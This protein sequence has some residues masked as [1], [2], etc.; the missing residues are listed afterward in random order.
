MVTLGGGYAN[1][2]YRIKGS[3]ADA[4]LRIFARDGTRRDM[5][6]ALLAQVTPVV[7]VPEVLWS[8]EVGGQS[9]LLLSH[10]DGVLLDVVL[11]A[12]SAE[13][14]AACGQVVGQALAPIHDM[15]FDGTGFLDARLRPV[16]DARMTPGD[17]RAYAHRHLYDGAAGQVLGDAHRDAWWQLIDRSADVLSD[18]DGCARLVHADYNGKNIL[19]RQK[20]AGW[21]VA[22]VLDWEFAFAGPP[23]V[24]L[25]NLLR[26]PVPPAFE[27]ASVCGYL[28]AGGTLPEGWR[29]TAAVLDVFGLLGLLRPGSALAGPVRELVDGQVRRGSLVP[30]RP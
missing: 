26:F 13:D 21:A 30:D 27:P 5:E 23:L 10:V 20:A 24:D 7:P 6:V 18:V 15:A 29:A 1:A 2:T 16:G 3:D 11:A 25:G 12:G 14:V 22:A 8:G 28:D 9:A 17:L 4:V 19:V